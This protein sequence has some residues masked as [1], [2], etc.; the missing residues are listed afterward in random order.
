MK[1]W[2]AGCLVLLSITAFGDTD[3]RLWLS[4]FTLRET[5]YDV[6]SSSGQLTEEELVTRISN[7]AII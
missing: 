4:R 6:S 1:T 5:F 7:N 2:L 3:Q